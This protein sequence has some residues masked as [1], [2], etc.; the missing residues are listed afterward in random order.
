M[1][2]YVNRRSV[3]DGPGLSK[4]GKKQ[5]TKKDLPMNTVIFLVKEYALCVH[6]IFQTDYG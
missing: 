6:I 1:K 3:A 4:Q 5:K 2:Y